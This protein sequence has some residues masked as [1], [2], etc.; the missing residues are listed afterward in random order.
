M[1]T[2]TNFFVLVKYHIEQ[3]YYST[4]IRARRVYRAIR[5]ID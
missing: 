2:S 3:T 5:V 1:N 4:G